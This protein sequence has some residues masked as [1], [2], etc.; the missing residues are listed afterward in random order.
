MSTAAPPT[1]RVVFHSVLQILHDSFLADHLLYPSLVVNI[2]GII[3]EAF[4][5]PLSF[6]AFPSFPVL[7]IAEYLTKS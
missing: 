1:F 2:E 7:A 3:V 6:D 5:L 4:N